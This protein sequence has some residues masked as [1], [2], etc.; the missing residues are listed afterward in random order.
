[1]KFT[2][3]TRRTAI[4][5]AAALSL[6]IVSIAAG[7]VAAAHREVTIEVDGVSQ[8]I[9]GFMVTVGDVLK[10]AGV[11]PA[12]HDEVAPHPTELISNGATVVVRSAHPY[13]VNENGTHRTV[14][15]TAPT[16]NA[17]VN[18]LNNGV[19]L[20][21]NRSSERAEVPLIDNTGKV[22]I[23][24]DSKKI[25]VEAAPSDTVATLLKKANVTVSGIDRVSMQS[26]NG[27]LTLKI[28]RITRGNKTVTEA[29]PASVEE[30]EDDSMY[31]GSTTVLQEGADGTVT[32]T[33][34]V[35]TE[36]GKPV[37]QR[38]ISQ[39]R[40]E[41]V[42]RI[43]ATGTKPR[44][45]GATAAATP[46]GGG[47]APEGV[48]AALAQCESGGNPHINTGNGFYGMYQFSLPTWQSVGG[49]GLPSDASAEEQTMRA[50]ILQQRAGW[51]QWPACSASLGLY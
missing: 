40:I 8:P 49:S 2:H 33:S 24:V 1:M 6:G 7:G 50:Q 46:S 39:Q 18:S 30:R 48:W 17:F 51:G 13:L 35:E 21:A 43:I 37:F 20:A 9:S 32:T 11:T 3:P 25:P 22:V 44:P 34:Y 29:I 27:Q 5:V 31:E 38:Q 42:T 15:S 47:V 45:A 14:W 36:D 26:E 4:S 41:P 12:E 23:A 19:T 28:T 16:I 10:Q